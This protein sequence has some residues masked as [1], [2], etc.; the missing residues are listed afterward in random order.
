MIIMKILQVLAVAAAT[1]GFLLFK[2]FYWI[3]AENRRRE[4]LRQNALSDFA[5]VHFSQ[6]GFACRNEVFEEVQSIKD[7]GEVGAKLEMRAR[8]ASFP[9]PSSL[10]PYEGRERIIERFASFVTGAAFGAAAGAGEQFFYSLFE[11][12][13]E[14]PF[15]ETV[16]FLAGYTGQQIAIGVHDASG[17]VAPAFHQLWQLLIH[18]YHDNPTEALKLF[19]ASAEW[20]SLPSE[21]HFLGVLKHVFN[22]DHLHIYG[23]SFSQVAHPIAESLSHSAAAV[24]E[25]L[26]HVDIHSFAL[27]HDA[28][29]PHFHFPVVTLVLSTTREIRL[30]SDEKTTLG[31]S[32]KNAS[33]D[34]AG[35]GIG[36][37]GG[38]KAGAL[39]GSLIAPG[40]GTLI[41]GILGGVAGA[42]G[43]RFVTDKVKTIHLREVKEIYDRKASSME[44]ETTTAA[45]NLY[46]GASVAISKNQQLY[47]KAIGNTQPISEAVSSL[48][49]DA[50]GIAAMVKEEFRRC[51]DELAENRQKIIVCIPRDS[52]YHH[53]TGG[54][55]AREVIQQLD[56]VFYEK[57]RRLQ[58]GE[59]RIPPEDLCSHEPLS[60]LQQLASLHYPGSA[61]FE[62]PLQESAQKLRLVKAEYLS[63]LL[64]WARRAAQRYQEAMG[65]AQASIAADAERFQELCKRWTQEV[66]A[67]AAE[68]NVELAKH[69]R[70]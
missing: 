63:S 4:N 5:A 39:L 37:F 7:A 2:L 30:L 19:A 59:S 56:A 43:L 50:N 32:F 49:S 68:V 65:S 64:I 70:A 1:L 6:R 31:E 25:H 60:A 15:A 48:S 3:V 24:H 14:T 12:L 23:E 69:G 28:G 9:T 18:Y 54:A 40:P 27:P 58:L 35:T 10:S 21:E 47:L 62:T 46:N 17:H 29:V 45:R 36:G 44:L 42:F 38:A 13:K 33:L 41:G 52:W 55:G 66:K 57:D 16:A 11:G 53:L 34:V 67:A 26:S 22:A 51:R 61:A 8:Q 20:M